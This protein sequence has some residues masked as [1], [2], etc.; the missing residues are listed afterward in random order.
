MPFAAVAVSLVSGLE[1]RISEQMSTDHQKRI[2]KL[3]QGANPNRSE[4]VGPRSGEEYWTP[5]RLAAARE[6]LEH[7]ADALRADIEREQ[8]KFDEDRDAVVE[9]RVRDEGDDSVAD[10]LVDLD[11]SEID[12]D[13]AELEDI[14]AALARIKAGTYGYCIDCGEPIYPQRLERLPAAARDLACQERFE[15]QHGADATPSL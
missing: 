15:A 13:L 6:R 5:A 4:E 1:K 2:A 11:L 12:R 8:S 3:G 10:L 9:D 7:R 14:Q